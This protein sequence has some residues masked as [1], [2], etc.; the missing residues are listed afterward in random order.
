MRGVHSGWIGAK[1]M[2]RRNERR[3]HAAR[4][5][6]R[7]CEPVSMWAVSGRRDGPPQPT[8]RRW[9]GGSR[10]GLGKV[11][12]SP[13]QRN[14]CQWRPP[15]TEP[16]PQGVR[17]LWAAQNRLGLRAQPSTHGTALPTV[18]KQAPTWSPHEQKPARWSVA[19]LESTTSPTRCRCQCQCTRGRS[20][21]HALADCH[22]A[23]KKIHVE[24]YAPHK[25]PRRRTMNTYLTY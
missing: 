4:Q 3:R 21:T 12:R 20:A 1:W 18:I 16:R 9:P 8:R 5:S 7:C 25:G 24:R 22:R 23:S 11:Q 10:S 13:T 19:T 6:P 15:R 17:N 14:L 2:D